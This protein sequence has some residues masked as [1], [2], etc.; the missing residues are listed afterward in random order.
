MEN[1]MFVCVYVYLYGLKKE[2]TRKYQVRVKFVQK[3]K[4]WAITSISSIVKL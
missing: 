1:K 4:I 2:I 3:G